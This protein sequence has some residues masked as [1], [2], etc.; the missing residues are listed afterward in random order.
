MSWQPSLRFR[1]PGPAT[2]VAPCQRLLR[3][4]QT[5]GQSP[6]LPPYPPVGDIRATNPPGR[7]KG[8]RPSLGGS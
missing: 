6:G 1:G 4:R 2:S 3:A 8:R 7:V 5:G